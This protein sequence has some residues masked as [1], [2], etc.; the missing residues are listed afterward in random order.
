[1]RYCE[2]RNATFARLT[3]LSP[4]NALPV[5]IAA[6]EEVFAIWFSPEFATTETVFCSVAVLRRF[7]RRLCRFEHG[8]PSHKPL[9]ALALRRSIVLAESGKFANK[10]E[11]EEFT[12][13][14]LRRLRISASASEFPVTIVVE[15]VG[16]SVAAVTV[17][18]AAPTE[19]GI[20]LVVD[21][22]VASG[23]VVA[24]LDA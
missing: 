8:D 10:I 20:S 11:P 7:T 14:V 24:V 6:L 1:M 18:A 5:E 15:A 9:N 4:A 22:A 19:T 13:E 2:S 12:N 3:R 21:G 16:V 23:V 17:S